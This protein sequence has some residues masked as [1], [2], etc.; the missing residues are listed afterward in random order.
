MP[1]TLLVLLL[2]L[3]TA[4]G[5]WLSF[6]QGRHVHGRRGA[7]PADFAGA[8]S[9]EDHAKAADYTLAKQKL[10]I[11][12]ALWGLA[13]TLAWLFFGITA[14]H[15]LVG[16]FSA[17]P[18]W[19]GTSLILAMIVISGVIDIPLDVVKTFGIETKFGFNR[20]SPRLF[21]M[22]W[23]KG[24]LLNLLLG[25]PLIYGLL[26]LIGGMSGLWWLWAWAGFL[27][28][29]GTLMAVYPIW[30]A[31]LF[32]KF[33]PLPD[34][35]V[36][37]RV[38]TLL[39][40]AGYRS[41][42]LFVMDGSKRS[43]HANAYFTGFG[44]T[45]RIVF[46]DTLLAK[47]TPDETE[48][49]LAHELGHFHHRDTIRSIARLA[50]VSLIVF[51]WLGVAVKQPWFTAWMG[52]PASD[53][54]AI[55]VAMICIGPVGLVFAPLTNWVSWKAEWRADAYAVAL[56]GGGG[57]LSS[58]LVKLSRDSASTLT[59]DPLFARFHYSHP[60]LPLRLARLHGQPQPAGRPL[61]ASGF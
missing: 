36:K 12:G 45:K 4:I 43:S 24:V 30:I 41:G 16:Q 60:P 20:I 39:A 9:L 25:T 15:D 47:L 8:V 37:T 23:A 27:I 28:F 22:D 10:A 54:V 6:R 61:G 19:A 51:F 40:K 5:I 2:A 14:L 57:H 33:K 18:L 46:F 48:A 7:V 49:V 26:W 55:I 29:T 17:T 13:V 44:R 1:L 11:F 50:A 53:A 52:L 34:G 38:E 35:E 31:P 58:A 59:P 32:N 21:A 56:T 3:S 42:G